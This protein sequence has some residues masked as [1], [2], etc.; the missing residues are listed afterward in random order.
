MSSCYTERGDIYFLDAPGGTGKT[1]TLKLLLATVRQ[2]G[3]IAIATASSGIA[4]TLLDG[5]RTAH[6]TFKLSLQ[7]HMEDTRICGIEKNSNMADVLR[8]AKLIVLDEV[9]MIHKKAIEALNTSLRDLQLQA[10]DQPPNKRKNE[11]MGGCTVL[12]SGDF[13]QILPVVKRGSRADEVNASLK[14]SALWPKIKVLS[15]KKNMRVHLK[16]DPEAGKLS[17]LLFKLGEGKI[18]SSEGK[19][20]VPNELC[21]VVNDLK[22]LTDKIYPDTRNILSKP[23][24]WLQE[25]AILTPLNQTANEINNLL[26]DQMDSL[27]HT[28]KSFDSCM[29]PDQACNFPTEVLNSFNTLSG[30]KNFVFD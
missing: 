29:D 26:M 8:Q 28:Y 1:F 17:E 7:L 20:E 12:L 4:A 19:I 23:I 14:N 13:R 22:S 24:E 15:L 25:R 10:K 16:G 2:R 5:G 6:S 9:T 3:D 21:Q 11:L 27:G 30:K 18:I